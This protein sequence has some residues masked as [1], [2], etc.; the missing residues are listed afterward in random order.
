M[1]FMM[2][3]SQNGKSEFR[4]HTE[5]ET[6]HDDWPR[7][8][9]VPDGVIRAFSISETFVAWFVLDDL[10]DL[11]RR[12]VKPLGDGRWY[13]ELTKAH[14]EKFCL[15]EGMEISCL[16][17]PVPQVPEGLE[18]A[19]KEAG[20]IDRWNDLTTAQQRGFSEEV[21]AAKSST[22]AEKRIKK[23]VDC[24]AAGR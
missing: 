5:L 15:A 9:P 13:F 6:C 18:Q 20:L 2:G 10:G 11:G 16:V 12:T 3:G 1:L 7:I 4:F 21:F 24:L 23:V 14:C 19:L 22:T 17:S 8:A